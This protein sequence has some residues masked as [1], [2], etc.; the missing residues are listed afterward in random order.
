MYDEFYL[1]SPNATY[2]LRGR[3]YRN[4]DFER[5]VTE[6]AGTDMSDFFKR[7]VRGVE[8]PPYEEAF[9]QV[10][11]RFIREPRQT[12]SVGISSDESDKTNFKIASVRP[13][14][15]AA[16]AGFDVG[17]IILSFGGIKLMPEN[18]VKTLSRF[19]PGDRVAVTLQRGSRKIQTFI[20][21]GQPQV[22]D[23][24][25]E[26]SANASAE[27]KALRGAWLKG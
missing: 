25:I 3:G 20:V 23:Y 27:A 17:D 14:S 16:T 6:V 26:D 24:R 21:L 22:M 5:V 11:L 19:K 9:A 1:K 8:P 4:E 2:Y 13:N 12:V 7:Y 10:G 15:P 18:L